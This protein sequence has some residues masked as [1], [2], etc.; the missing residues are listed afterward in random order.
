MIFAHF[1][2]MYMPGILCK[3]TGNHSQPHSS[4][5]LYDMADL[6]LKFS[7]IENGD[8]EKFKDFQGPGMNSR[9]FGG[10]SKP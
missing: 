1:S 9:D 5:R 8:Q 4:S 6:L 10:L 2:I 7:K 3:G